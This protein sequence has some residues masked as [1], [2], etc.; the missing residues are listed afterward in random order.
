MRAAKVATFVTL[1]LPLAW[2]A[3]QIVA[4]IAQPGSALGA[5]PGE[6]VV[7]HLGEWT[8]RVLLLTLCVSTARR[9]L[10]LGRLLQLRRMVGL[11]A[12]TYLCLHVLAYA[13]LLAG[14]DWV[15]VVDD[16]TER[17][18]IMV[19]MLAFVMLLPL[20][21]TSTRGWQR[22][23][24]R[25][26]RRLH[27]LVYPAALAGIVHLVWLTKDGYAEATLYAVLLGFLL[28]E[29]AWSRRRAA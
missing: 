5:D 10:G 7:L 11:F 8:L 4:E 15:A 2:L 29:R 28:A 23:L 1:C 22:R 17:P 9:L 6:A 18:Y 21:V 27:T 24:G 13:G 26:W 3:S 12:F 16:L 19:G 25:N 20:A 14:F